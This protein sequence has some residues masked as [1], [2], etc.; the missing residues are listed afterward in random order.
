MP[1]EPPEYEEEEEYER[2]RRRR[3]RREEAR[4]MVAGPAIALMV[5]GG[6]GVAGGLFALVFQ[7][8]G[9]GAGLHQPPFAQP[10]FG[11]PADPAAATVYTVSQVV[12]S[13]FGIGWSVFVLYGAYS[14]YKLQSYS[15]AM[16][17][18]IMGMIPCHSC[19]CLGLPFGIWSLVI[20]NR[21]EVKDAFSG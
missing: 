10:P 20:L 19:C 15:L 1:A 14:M 9:V 3:G 2:P 17:G 8:L 13:L 4:Q 18:S 16:A 7:V 5:A 21:P 6:L 12:G 11:P